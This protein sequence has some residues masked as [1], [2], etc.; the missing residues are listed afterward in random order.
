M[1]SKETISE[2]ICKCEKCFCNDLCMFLLL[3]TGV[4]TSC[5]DFQRRVR[6]VVDREIGN[7]N[8]NNGFNIE[9]LIKTFEDMANRGS[10]LIG[11][12]VTQQDL[13]M[14]IIGTIIKVSGQ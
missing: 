3:R 8:I 1:S 12:N 13:L 2:N 4:A 10:L 6:K 14:Q 9:E 11:P 7:I 5:E